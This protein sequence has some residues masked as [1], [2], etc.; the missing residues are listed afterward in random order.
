M[1]FSTIEYFIKEVY[2][3]FWR[4]KL[5]TLASVATV[6]IS[7]FIL[8][9]FALV[10]LNLNKMADTLESQVQV[11]VYLKD[12]ADDTQI[13]EVK[14]ALQQ[15]D[16]VQSVKFVA[17]E[18]AL[19]DF[20]SQLGDQDF[21]LDALDG[22]NPLPNAFAVTVNSSDEVRAT[23]HTAEN[24]AGVEA[25]S[26]SQDIIDHLF[27]LTHLL[28]LSGTAVIILLLGAAVFI[29]SNTIRLTVFARRKEI[30]IMKYVGATNWFIR[31]PF[32]LEG[33]SLGFVGGGAASLLLY[34]VYTSMVQ[35]IYQVM[36]FFPLISLHPAMDYLALALTGCGILIGM[37]G[38]VVS[39]KRYLKV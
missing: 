5:M 35:A 20:R 6:A 1:K 12:A 38:S 28:R 11:N 8:G 2:L 14:T 22:T 13:D 33:V 9:F 18:Q 17:K 25:V 23:A 34:A 16:G 32:L 24:L 15:I 31:W 21:L 19:E 3:S 36:A 7:L 4:N 27:G 26:Y 30:A 10:V 29:I 39:L 37:A